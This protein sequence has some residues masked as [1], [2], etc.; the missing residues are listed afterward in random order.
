MG[1]TFVYNAGEA[2]NPADKLELVFGLFFD[3]QKAENQQ[4]K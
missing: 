1:K 4:K 2:K 3:G